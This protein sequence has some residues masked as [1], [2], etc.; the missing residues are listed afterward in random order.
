[1]TDAY[2][3]PWFGPSIGTITSKYQPVPCPPN[4]PL[5]ASG[6]GHITIGE[7]PTAPVSASDGGAIPRRTSPAGYRE[8]AFGTHIR[9]AIQI[10]KDWWNAI[11]A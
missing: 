3:T 6:A 4:C 10:L 2:K 1:M 9:E 11:P 8:R 7:I 5:C